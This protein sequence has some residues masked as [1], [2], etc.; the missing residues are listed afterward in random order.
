M[1]QLFFFRHFHKFTPK[2]FKQSCLLGHS[3]W[4]LSERLLTS[5]SLLCYETCPNSG[6][7][8][9]SGLLGL[10]S[11]RSDISRCRL[12]LSSLAPLHTSESGKFTLINWLIAGM[13][14]VVGWKTLMENQ[15]LK[16]DFFACLRLLEEMN[17]LLDPHSELLLVFLT[18][19]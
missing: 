3:F 15:I 13:I 10:S 1:T 18:L 19:V 17:T 16:Y 14:Y 12:G 6:T 8:L 11:G 9:F 2:N 7:L 4:Q 5:I